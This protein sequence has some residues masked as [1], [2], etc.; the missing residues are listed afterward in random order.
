MVSVEGMVKKPMKWALTDLIKGIPVEDRIYRM[1]CVEAWSMV[2]PWNGV[3]LAEVI[4]RLEPTPAAKYVVFKTL[5]DPKQL[6]GEQDR[7]LQTGPS[8]KAC[9]WTAMN[10]LALMAAGIYGK[11]LPSQDGAPWRL[12]SGTAS[13]R[14]RSRRSS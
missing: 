10:P 4:K 9:V 11:P 2:I 5:Y 8:P 1:R 14:E 12:V 13:R 7:G 3:P 6:P